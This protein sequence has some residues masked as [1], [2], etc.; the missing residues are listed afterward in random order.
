MPFIINYPIY[1]SKSLKKCCYY[2]ASLYNADGEDNLCGSE[3]KSSACKKF[4]VLACC[5][6]CSYDVHAHLCSY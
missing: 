4:D 3:T 2:I 5:H 6:A 1:H